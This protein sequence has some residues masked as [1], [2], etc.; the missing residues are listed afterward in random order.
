MVVMQLPLPLVQFFFSE[1]AKG[2][3]CTYTIYVFMWREFDGRVLRICQ[4]YVRPTFQ[5]ALAFGAQ[6]RDINILNRLCQ[7][8]KWSRS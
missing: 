6:A 8:L 7:Q 2:I 3:L 1:I 5:K 4:K